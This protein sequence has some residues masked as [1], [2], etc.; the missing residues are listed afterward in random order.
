MYICKSLLDILL[1]YIS[2][3]IPF[4][5]F[6]SENPYP[7]PPPPAPQSTRSCILALAVPCTGA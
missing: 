5:G 2:N 4:P 6:S 3:V 1:I 7:L